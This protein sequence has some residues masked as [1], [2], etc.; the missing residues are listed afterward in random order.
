MF[1]LASFSELSTHRDRLLNK[2]RSYVPCDIESNVPFSIDHIS[3]HPVSLHATILDAMRYPS[4]LLQGRLS[5]RGY[6]VR[7]SFSPAAARMVVPCR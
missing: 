1:Y 7:R 4:M 2:F 5:R 3:E 6:N